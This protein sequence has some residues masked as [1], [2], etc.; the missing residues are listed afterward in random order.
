MF[1][2]KTMKRSEEPYDDQQEMAG[3]EIIESDTQNESVVILYGPITTENI[4]Q[5][6]H[7][8]IMANLAGHKRL[9]LVIMSS[10]GNLTAAFGLIDTMAGSMVPIVTYGIGEV[11]SAGLLI[12]MAGHHRVLSRNTSILSHQFSTGSGWNKF[13]EMEALERGL[14]MT[15]KQVIKFYVK[16]TKLPLRTIKAKLLSSSDT[17]LT[18]DEALKYNLA[19]EVVDGFSLYTLASDPLDELESTEPQLLQEETHENSTGV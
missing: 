9:H 14:K 11:L 5:A 18:A 3:C 19:D 10:G 8:I 6:I 7:Q 16:A 2:S 4:A 13:H 12:L 1:R 15:Q 17:W